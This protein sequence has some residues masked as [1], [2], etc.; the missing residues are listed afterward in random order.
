[1]IKSFRGLLDNDE[2]ETIRLSTKQGK[3]G[4]VI[5]KFQV[6]GSTPG[7]SGNA[8][9]VCKIYSLPQTTVDGVIDFSDPTLLAVATWMSSSDSWWTDKT[10]IFDN[11]VINQD[12]Y[13]TFTDEQ[14]NIALN[15]YL[16]LEVMKLNDNEAAV[17]TLMDIRASAKPPAEP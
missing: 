5:R 6:I 8:E 9:A 7:I 1:M 16:E 10:I 12:I 3:I 4:Y 15:Y 17:A 13:V 14:G 11:M 2:T